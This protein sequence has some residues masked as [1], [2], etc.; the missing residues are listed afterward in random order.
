MH[1]LASLIW[2]IA[3]WGICGG[4]ISRIAIVQAATMRQTRSIDA[5]YFALANAG[6]LILAPLCPLLGIAFCGLLGAAF[7]LFYRLPLVGPALAGFGLI[8]PLA[9]GLVM[10]LFLAGLAAG[11]PLLQAATAGG[12]EDALDALSRI[13]GYLNQRLGSYAV[14]VALAWLGGM[15]GLALVDLLTSGVIRLTHW[16]VGLTAP[17]GLTESFFGSPPTS[18]STIAAATHAFWLGVVRLLAHGWVFSFFWTAAA[19]LYLWLRLDIDG[20]PWTEIDPPVFDAG[21]SR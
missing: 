3:V 18:S 8:F 17:I 13:F 4:A 11:W 10:S 16:S 6:P 9:A 20:S 14:L 1:V 2:L 7:G 21:P 15:L 12:A 5:L 19:Y